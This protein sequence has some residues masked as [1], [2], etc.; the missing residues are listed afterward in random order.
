MIRQAWVVGLAGAMLVGCESAK[1][2]TP[3]VERSSSLR[4]PLPDGWRATAS[5]G[6]L[7]VGPQGRVVLQLESTTK[8]LPSAEA[9][10]SAI[11]AEGVEILEKESV[12]TFIGVRYSMTA[13]GA[14]RDAF[15]GV[16][17]TGPRTIW[18]STTG[19]AHSD[20]VEAAMTVC[21][22]LSWEG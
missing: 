13:D 2:T 4:V 10:V 17:Q 1:P 8:P 18:C 7:Q 19:S 16:R 6:G 11:T 5:S 20:E 14:K 15:L 12:D 21:R 3:P 22:S 9:F